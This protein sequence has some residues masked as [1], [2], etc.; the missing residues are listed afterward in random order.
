M[1]KDA[2][3]PSGLV[4]PPSHVPVSGIDPASVGIGGKG[5]GDV[6]A[7]VAVGEAQA[8]STHSSRRVDMRRMSAV[9]VNQQYS[10]P[11]HRGVQS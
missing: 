3:E 7:R 11:L 4:A 6:G 2:I 10:S 8:D 5:V 9:Y 1:E